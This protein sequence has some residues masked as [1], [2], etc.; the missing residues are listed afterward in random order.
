LK[1]IYR[2]MEMFQAAAPGG[3]VI[4]RLLSLAT[5]AAVGAAAVL[6]TASPVSAGHPGR[7][8]NGYVGLTF[9]DGPSAATTTALLDA[10]V[11]GRARA[12][13]FNMGANEQQVPDLVRA[14]VAAGMWIGNHTVTH[15]HLTQIGEPAAFE[16]IAQTQ[17][18]TRGDHRAL[19]QALPTPVR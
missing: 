8:R 9:D 15:P 19:A 4:R 14:E 10:L 6:A 1:H 13:F 12:T 18:I 17:E 2:W 11:A 7:C 5:V 16:E 3:P